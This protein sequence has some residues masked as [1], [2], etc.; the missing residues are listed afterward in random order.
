MTSDS[1][2]VWEFLLHSFDFM[3]PRPLRKSNQLHRQGSQGLRRKPLDQSWGATIFGR[4][5]ILGLKPRKKGCFGFQ[6]YIY[7]STSTSTSLCLQC[8]SLSFYIHT[9]PNLPIRN[10]LHFRL[11]ASA[12]GPR[13]VRSLDMRAAT[14]WRR[15]WRNISEVKRRCGY[16]VLVM[17]VVGSWRSTAIYT[18]LMICVVF[19]HERWWIIEDE[20]EG[21]VKPFEWKTWSQ[22]MFA[23]FCSSIQNKY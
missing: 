3:F 19:T 8:I 7:I 12:Q 23:V 15:R 13:C 9:I 1:I 20:S 16:G 10:S 2:W 18:Y 5:T 11:N 21:Y 17:E 22:N 14:W 6:V 4:T